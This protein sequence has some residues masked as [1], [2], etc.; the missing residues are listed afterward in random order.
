M[1]S[2][3]TVPTLP[4]TVQTLDELAKSD[5]AK[6]AVQIGTSTYS[7]LKSQKYPIYAKL[8]N[9]IQNECPK[10]CF[11]PHTVDMGQFLNDNPDKFFITEEAFA[12][13]YTLGIVKDTFI[14]LI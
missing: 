10:T 6:P 14:R 1:I 2:V 12:E 7:L 9:K 3:L 11:K 13:Y 4:K 8:W 5:Y